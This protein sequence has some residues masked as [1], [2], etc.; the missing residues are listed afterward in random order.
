MLRIKD[1]SLVPPGGAFRYVHAV[2][3]AEFKHHTVTHLYEMVRKHCESNGYPFDNA[4][5]NNNVCANAHPMVCHEVDDAG[6]PPLVERVAS[7]A[8]AIVSHGRN[9]FKSSN[10]EL[11]E[12]RL[13]VC[14]QCS[15][16]GGETG[17]SWFGILCRKCGC[18]SLKLKWRSS[19]CPIGSW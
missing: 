11:Q 14:R 12:Q 4:E 17:G 10:E 7:F 19:K 3:G 16:Y 2:S 8:K 18:S 13:S 1:S 15:F 9:G 5:F 6:L